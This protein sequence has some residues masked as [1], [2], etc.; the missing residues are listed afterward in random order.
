MWRRLLILSTYPLF[1][2]EFSEVAIGKSIKRAVEEKKLIAINKRLWADL[3]ISSYEV[4][5]RFCI[6]KNDC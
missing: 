1:F 6:E 4:F 2:L 5:P 3:W